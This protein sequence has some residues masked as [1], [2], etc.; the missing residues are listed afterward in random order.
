[1]SDDNSKLAVAT[2]QPMASTQLSTFLG[3]EKGMMIETL[4]AQCF[5]GLR[6][7]QVTDAQLAS[8]ISVANAQR[9]NPLLPGMLYA[10]PERNGGIT[11]IVGPDGAFKKLDEHI[12]EGK[13][14]GYECTVFPEDASQKPTHAT[15]VIYRKD[16]PDHPSRY[17][18]YF[19]EWVVSSNPNWQVKPRHMLWLRALKQCARQVIHGMPMDADEHKLAEMLNVT[20]SVSR[21][22]TGPVV[23]DEP[24]V[25]TEAGG[26]ARAKIDALLADAKAAEA[27]KEK[28]AATTEPR[29]GPGRPPK[30]K[31]AAVIE[32]TATPVS[33]SKAPKTALKDGE[34]FIAVC[35]VVSFKADMVKSGGVDLPSVIAEV[36]GEFKGKVY[37]LNGAPLADGQQIPAHAWQ[38]DKP[39]VIELLGKARKDPAAPCTIFVEAIKIHEPVAQTAPAAQETS[40]VD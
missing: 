8:F 6:P 1:M 27:V 3:I 21:E 13:L 5:K 12:A 17:T 38:T 23:R 15:A 2:P 28:A 37:H 39:V 11:P 16:A 9:L 33:E 10:Y 14:A 7:E 40:D 29:K 30:N 35:R 18:A 26:V 4:K 19:S 34:K 25:K 24:P 20:D 22:E 32:T 36:D 31:D